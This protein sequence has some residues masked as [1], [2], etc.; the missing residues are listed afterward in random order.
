MARWVVVYARIEKDKY[1]LGALEPFDDREE[2]IRTA[3][4]MEAEGYAW[5][6]VI[7]EYW[8]D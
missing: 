1:D 6:G 2:A 3:K 5:A 4:E 7:E 8:R